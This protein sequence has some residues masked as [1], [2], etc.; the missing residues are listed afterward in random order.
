MQEGDEAKIAELV[1]Q[2]EALGG[3]AREA[4]A[5]INAA[6]LTI[7]Q[8]AEQTALLVRDQH[9]L[10]DAAR[11]LEGERDAAA[12]DA[13]DLCETVADV[14]T[15]KKH[16]KERLAANRT[17]MDELHAVRKELKAQL[18]AEIAEKE[19]L[20]GATEG[21]L[22]ST[23]KVADAKANLDAQLEEESAAKEALTSTLDGTRTEVDALKR[24]IADSKAQLEGITNEKDAA[25]AE[26][27]GDK[28]ELLGVL[29]TLGT[30]LTVASTKQAST[31]EAQREKAAALAD[32]LAADM[33]G[34]AGATGGTVVAG[35]E[36]EVVA[37]ADARVP[38][39]GVDRSRA[40]AL[41]HSLA[42]DMAAL[43]GDEQG[44][45]AVMAMKG[46][47][48]GAAAGR[49]SALEAQHAKALGLERGL[50]EAAAAGGGA[51]A[52]AGKGSA[53]TTA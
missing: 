11:A 53:T 47:L 4:V 3:E 40:Q 16:V 15:E 24:R 49:V 12:A 45:T 31:L 9:M 20:E 18:D 26:L 36:A 21:L 27:V 38:A 30:E 5:K 43:Q 42:N 52:V 50:G 8:L 13:T 48:R 29:G 23:A 35:V 28:E 17:K 22:A 41:V 32:S 44:G 14:S 6:T 51:A 46:G 25:I 19:E 37:A 1:S 39:L 10:D 7:D 34:G 33:E 2:T